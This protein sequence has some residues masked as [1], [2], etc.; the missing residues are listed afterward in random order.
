[1][2]GDSGESRIAEDK[3]SGVFL[4]LPGDDKPR[5][6]RAIY[7]DGTRLSGDL[8]KN[9]KRIA[10][11]EGP[12]R[13][14]A[15]QAADVWIAIAGHDEASGRAAIGQERLD[16][17]ARAGRLAPAWPVGG[18]TSGS[19]RELPG[20]AAA[21]QRRRPVRS[22]RASPGESFTE[23]LLRGPRRACP[24]RSRAWFLSAPLSR[25]SPPESEAWS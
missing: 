9:R 12:G 19:R 4:S 22:S 15:V 7:Q 16:R 18:W 20:L 2:K 1:M 25:A 24:P 3:I 5:A 11:N 21:G 14:P 10:G 8:E 6:I 17:P 23:S 13:Q